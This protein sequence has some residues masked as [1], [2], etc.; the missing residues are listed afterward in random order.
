[1]AESSGEKSFDPTP[2][3][4]EQFKK[5]GRFARSKDAA[6]VG[7]TAAVL[8]VLLGSSAAI[9]SA[10][11]LLFQRCHGDLG[12]FARRDGDGIGQA[13]L[14]VFTVT[15]VPSIV[16]AALAG[17]L[18]TIVQ[19]GGRMNDGFGFD[20]TRL[21]PLP[22]LQQLFSP[23]QGAKE[24]TLSLLRVGVVGYVA[25]LALVREIPGLLLLART[26]LHAGVSAMVGA[27]VHVITNALGALAMV[28]AIDF[29]Q[30]KF[31][32]EREMKMTRQEIMDE[33]KQQDG[34]PKI[35]A[36]MRQRARAMARRRSM[37]NVKS[38]TVII[39]NPTHISIALRYSK[40]DAAP[41]VVAKGHDDVAM[42]IRAEARKHG[43]PILENR[44]L[45]RAL[46]AEVPVGRPVPAAHFAAVA[47]ILAFVYK[48]RGARSR[49]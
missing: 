23:M 28:S 14:G 29:A 5:Q 8:A 31:T 15:A 46:D 41:V 45:A 10:M 12:A 39:A 3:R 38:A 32:L 49:V 35:K 47:R 9:S 1:M 4:R 44:P 33:T 7:S 2:H 40:T 26:D 18:I 48:I 19:T 11:H 24:T 13:V 30:S 16:A 37:Q 36:R 22:K 20:P 25:Y 43:I 6:A 34:D 21:N 27:S 42:Q 17:S